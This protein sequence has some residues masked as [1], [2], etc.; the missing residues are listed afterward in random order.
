MVVV[1]IMEKNKVDT[2]LAISN[3]IVDRLETSGFSRLELY[4]SLIPKL[5]EI[6]EMLKFGQEFNSELGTSF[7]SAFDLFIEKISSKD[8]LVNI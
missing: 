3:L 6:S 1:N 8:Y 2:I 4:G 5:K 7:D